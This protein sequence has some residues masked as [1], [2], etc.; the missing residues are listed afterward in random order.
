[1]VA[2]VADTMGTSSPLIRSVATP[3][4]M[5]VSIEASDGNRYEADLS[6][7]STVYCFPRTAEEWS[8]VSLDSYGLSL[9]WASRFEV[10]VDQVVGLADH[11]E[12]AAASTVSPSATS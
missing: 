11:V 7:F 2:G 4:Y 9:V 5:R 10:H 12:P 1:M 3:A 8:R 6:S